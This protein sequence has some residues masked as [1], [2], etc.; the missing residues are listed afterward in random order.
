MKPVTQFFGL[1]ACGALAACGPA[2]GES[3]ASNLECA[4]LISASTYRV[5]SAKAETDPVLKKRAPTTP[6]TYLNAYAIPK[7]IKQKQACEDL[8]SLRK[9]L[10]R[11]RPPGHIMSRARTCVD[12][13]PT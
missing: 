1:I 9:D 12:R 10:M 11:S 6:M 7:G 3:A 13:S 8:T 4:A 2:E 5:A